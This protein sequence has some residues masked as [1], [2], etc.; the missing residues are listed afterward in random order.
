MKLLRKGLN[1]LIIIVVVI[2]LII[3]ALCVFVDPNR[4]KPIITAQIQ[5]QTDYQLD[6]VGNF[7]WSF[8]P[9]VG[10]KAEGMSLTAPQQ[11]APFAEMK[12]VTLGMDLFQLLRGNSNL[13]G[14]IHIKYLTLMNLHMQNVSADM[15]W[16]DNIFTISPISAVLY[17]GWMSGTVHGRDLSK[18][19][20]WDWDMQFSRV[21]IKPLLFDLNGQDNK[22]DISGIGQLRMEA[23]TTGNTKSELI[24][25]MHGNLKYGLTNGVVS[26]IDLNYYIATAVE[27]INRQPVSSPSDTMQT[28]FESLTGSMRLR[29]GVASTD[30]T[31]LVSSAV[32]VKATGNLDLIRDSI[33]YALDIV[34]QHLE[35]FKWSIPVLITGSLQSPNVKLDTLKI[36]TIIANEQFQRLKEKAEDKLKKMPKGVENLLQK[37]F[38][39]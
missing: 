14:D 1:V 11:K 12:E 25:H 27:L 36:N 24:N 28:S 6:I 19:P 29:N 35:A 21:Q 10:I 22:L 18:V 15:A 37:V 16:E 23:D 38:G 33:D 2:A 20:H 31:I 26:G 32:T 9:R 5:K 8:Y 3:T 39:H 13:S 4:L 17:D 34:P 7:S 30:D